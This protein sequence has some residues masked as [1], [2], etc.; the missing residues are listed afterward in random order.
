MSKHLNCSRDLLTKFQQLL[1]HNR[2]MQCIFSLQQS[3]RNSGNVVYTIELIKLRANCI[4][5]KAEQCFHVVLFLFLSLW[6]KPQSDHSNEC[7][8]AVLSRGTFYYAIQGSLWMKRGC[9]TIPMK[10]IQQYFRVKLFVFQLSS[11]GKI[12]ITFW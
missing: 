9:V 3:K 11:G 4:Q 2:E 1:K 10:A 7:F 8:S 12:I 5:M 6:M